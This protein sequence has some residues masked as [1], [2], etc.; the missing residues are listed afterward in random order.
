MGLKHTHFYCSLL[1]GSWW[2]INIITR[3][4][5]GAVNTSSRGRAITQSMN[6]HAVTDLHCN[7]P[8][9][10]TRKVP[11]QQH[12]NEHTNEHTTRKILTGYHTN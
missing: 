11:A 9:H 2:S 8:K 4:A 5:D 6:L 7:T 1:L 10:T 3:D 12:T